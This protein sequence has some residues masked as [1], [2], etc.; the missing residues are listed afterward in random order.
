MTHSEDEDILRREH[1]IGIEQRVRIIVEASGYGDIL[2]RM[3][4]GRIYSITHSVEVL[5]GSF[6]ETSASKSVGN[7]V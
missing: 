1:V 5:D 3:K 7:G 2:I 6:A 4:R